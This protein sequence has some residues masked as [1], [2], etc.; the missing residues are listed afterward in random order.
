MGAAY[1][2]KKD[3][4]CPSQKIKD[5]ADSMSLRSLRDFAKGSMK[6]LPEKVSENFMSFS[7][8]VNL[9]EQN[10]KEQNLNENKS[11]TCKCDSCKKGNCKK[12]TCKNCKCNGCTCKS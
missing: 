11:C 2:C 4:V 5:V 9:K 7:E 6:G 12:C 10:L 1:R 3:N 8:F